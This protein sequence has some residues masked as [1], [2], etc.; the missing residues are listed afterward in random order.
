M[1]GQ[2]RFV[3]IGL[4]VFVAAALVFVS[5]RQQIQLQRSLAKSKEEL[6]AAVPVEVVKP[7]KRELQETI[8]VMGTIRAL[9]DINIGSE[10]VGRVTY[11]GAREGDFVKAGQV[12]I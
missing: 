3:V 2:V 4:V 7:V 1:K 9:Q 12:L 6:R 11:V 10:L 8:Q 5:R